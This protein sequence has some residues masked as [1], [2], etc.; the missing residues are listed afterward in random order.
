VLAVSG[1]VDDRPDRDT[2]E[3]LPPHRL[4]T[5]AGWRLLLVHIVAPGPATKGG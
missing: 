4:L 2:E 5:V 1:N 3:L